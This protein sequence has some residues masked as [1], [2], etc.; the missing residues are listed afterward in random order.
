MVVVEIR[1]SDDLRKDLR[2]EIRET[3]EGS[4]LFKKIERAGKRIG[5]RYWDDQLD[6]VKKIHREFKEKQ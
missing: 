3:V 4:F 5:L 6:K 1:I 2:A